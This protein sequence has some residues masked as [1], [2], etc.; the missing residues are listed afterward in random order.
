MASGQIGCGRGRFV[1][2]AARSFHCSS[3][4]VDL[5]RCREVDFRFS[6]KFSPSLRRRF[7]ISRPRCGLAHSREYFSSNKCCSQQYDLTWNKYLDQDAQPYRT[8]VVK[9]GSIRDFRALFVQ[10][11]QDERGKCLEKSIYHLNIKCLLQYPNDGTSEIL[12]SVLMYDISLKNLFF[13][14]RTCRSCSYIGEHVGGEWIFFSNIWMRLNACLWWV[15]IL[16]LFHIE[17]KSEELFNLLWEIND[18]KLFNC[19]EFY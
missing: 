5:P 8:L 19:N 6:L 18:V 2:T 14:S 3:A 1:V 10:I 15:S 11:V 9:E 7:W 12:A 16:Y 4:G 17:S 13:L